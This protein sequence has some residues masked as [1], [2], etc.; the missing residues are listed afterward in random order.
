MSLVGKRQGS[1]FDFRDRVASVS[2]REETL[3]TRAEETAG[4]MV[5]VVVRR[6]KAM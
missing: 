4:G 3:L 2:C 1:T 5:V 6:M